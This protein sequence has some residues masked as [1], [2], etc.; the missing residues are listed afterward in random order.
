M[1]AYLACGLI[2]III[3]CVVLTRRVWGFC[4]DTQLCP[5]RSHILVSGI[6]INQKF[7][8][9]VTLLR[10]YTVPAVLGLH[11][12]LRQVHVVIYLY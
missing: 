5:S 11:E 6:V 3:L 1:Y 4:G 2:G 7:S 8:A 12:T 10:L 9:K